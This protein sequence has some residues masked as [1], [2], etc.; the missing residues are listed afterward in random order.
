LFAFAKAGQGVAHDVLFSSHRQKAHQNGFYFGSY[1]YYMAEVDWA[2]Q[3]KTFLTA[4]QDPRVAIENELPPVLDLEDRPGVNR[5]GTEN[6]Q[7]K[8]YAFLALLEQNIGKRPIL[9]CDPDFANN[10]LNDPRFA[11]YPLWLAAYQNNPP[12]PPCYWKQVTFWQNSEQGHLPSI[13]GSEVDLDFYL[14]DVLGLEKL[15]HPSVIPQFT[16]DNSKA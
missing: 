1:W 4:L 12:N 10:Y 14:G 7:R 3:L 15:V 5:I 8:I 11:E 9:Y 13:Q 6:F 16:G 2:E